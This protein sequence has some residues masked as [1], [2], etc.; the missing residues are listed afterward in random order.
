MNSTIFFLFFCIGL[1]EQLDFLFVM[2]LLRGRYLYISG[3][4]VKT[5]DWQIEFCSR[6]QMLE[7]S[8]LLKK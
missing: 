4:H 8:P 3:V 6:A 1:L 2:Q 5:T 7:K